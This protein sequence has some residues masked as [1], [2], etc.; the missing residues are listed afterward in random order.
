MAHRATFIG[1]WGMAFDSIPGIAPDR[2]WGS[3]EDNKLELPDGTETKITAIFRTDPST[4]RLQLSLGTPSHAFPSRINVSVDEYITTYESPGPK[5]TFGHGEARDY[6]RTEGLRS[7]AIIHKP[8]KIFLHWPD[9]DE[10]QPHRPVRDNSKDMH[11]TYDADTHI[12]L[13]Q[14]AHESL[15]TP[16][17]YPTFEQD[18]KDVGLEVISVHVPDWPPVPYSPLALVMGADGGT[19]KAPWWES[20][21]WEGEQPAIKRGKRLP[22]TYPDL[23]EFR[24]IPIPLQMRG[25]EDINEV[26]PNVSDD[27]KTYSVVRTTSSESVGTIARIVGRF[28]RGD[29]LSSKRLAYKWQVVPF[30]HGRHIA[31]MQWLDE[32]GLD[33]LEWLNEFYPAV[34][35][36]LGFDP[37]FDTTNPNAA[38]E[39]ED[40]GSYQAVIRAINESDI[41]PVL[42]AYKNKDTEQEE[43]DRPRPRRKVQPKPRRKRPTIIDTEPPAPNFTPPQPPP[44][45][46][47]VVAKAQTYLNRQ[48]VNVLAHSFEGNL[49]RIF[50]NAFAD[51]AIVAMTIEGLAAYLSWSDLDQQAY[52]KDTGGRNYVCDDFSM[53]L[54]ADSARHFGLNCVGIVWGNNHAWCF[55]VIVGK[56]GPQIVFV[57]PQIASYRYRDAS[58]EEFIAEILERDKQ[59]RKFQ[60][61]YDTSR[62]CEVM[63]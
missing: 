6:T 61:A 18:C 30:E 62:R 37:V 31:I 54:K 44:R 34:V 23:D 59:I 26:Y 35:K 28:M 24:H 63:L 20:R 55:V 5:Q 41:G 1:R 14:I 7:R 12:L 8:T 57:E 22:Y 21:F 46:P 4:L 49:P 50:G 27:G 15:L 43:V 11:D 60:A 51:S 16:E 39:Q 10:E 36:Q 33:R 45:S 47:A 40:A 25:R 29:A 58:A 53:S 19:T 3:L 48:V 56:D 38:Q 17:E 9:T 13:R 52:I 42:E 2:N 32:N